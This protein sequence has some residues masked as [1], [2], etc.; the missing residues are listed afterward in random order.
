MSGLLLPDAY[1]APN[2][3]YYALVG[4]G[5]TMGPT[6]PQGPAGA[7][8]AIGP[9]GPQGPAGAN[10]AIGPTGPQGLVGPTGP[11]GDTG[12]SSLVTITNLTPV[13]NGFPEYNQTINL[14]QGVY[15]LQLGL[16]TAQLTTSSP[17]NVFITM[18]VTSIGPNPDIFGS[19]SIAVTSFTNTSY[20]YGLS[21]NTGFFSHVGG[22]IN[23]VVSAN[24][25]TF[26]QGIQGSLQLVKFG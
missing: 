3:P 21:L 14:G 9:T 16:L 1:S 18:N 22:N 25:A 26:M 6:G 20:P 12:S 5:G 10:G 7:N 11:K 19:S 17:T 2:N 15:Q 23:I 8:G 13:L 24:T 4:S